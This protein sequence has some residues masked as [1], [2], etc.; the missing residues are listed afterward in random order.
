MHEIV[1]S[2]DYDEHV[3][4]LRRHYR[5]KLRATLDA[6]DEH[7]GSIPGVASFERPKRRAVSLGGIARRDGCRA[8]R[9]AVRPGRRRGRVLYPGRALLSNPEGGPRRTNVLRLSFGVPGCETIPR[10]RRVGTGVPKTRG[11]QFQIQIS[12]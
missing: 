7:L 4:M 6:A 12:N 11:S 10:C 5:Q 2:G 8:R 9:A 1:R 3:A